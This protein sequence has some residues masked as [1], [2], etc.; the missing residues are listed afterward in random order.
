L[1]SV[2]AYVDGFNL[3]HG[4]HDRFGHK[5]LWL[6]LEQLVRRLRPDDTVVA[7]KYFT[8]FVRDDVPAAIRQAV[9]LDALK[10]H[11]S[12]PLEIVL[13]R[14]QQR[15]VRCRA[16]G[17]RRVYHEEKE[18]DVNI[19]TAVVADAAA[20]SAD[21]ALLISADSDL[22]PAIRTARLLASQASRQ[23]GF[24][25]AFPPRRRSF[26]LTGTAST[27]KVSHQHL[28]QSQLP[29][30]VQDPATAQKYRRPPKWS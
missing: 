1:A 14:Y 18:T 2:I 4:I 29:P 27:C 7:V 12:A 24:I 10:A 5:Y 13:G 21:L 9:Y 19:A 23:L 6:D 15:L 25:V 17:A 11:A 22:C 20:G 26:E 3:Y 30:I 28:R 8:A 16:C